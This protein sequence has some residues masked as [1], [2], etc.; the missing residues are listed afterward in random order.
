MRS[1]ILS[2]AVAALVATSAMAGEG[3]Y[4]SG[5]FGQV[6][7]QAKEGSNQSDVFVAA[8]RDYGIYRAE[9]NFQSLNSTATSARVNANLGTAEVFAQYPIDKWTPYVGGGIGYGQFT[10]TGVKKA[11]DG[12]VYVAT[13]GVSYDFTKN[14]GAF[15]QY[16]YLRSSVKVTDA[17]GESNDY[18]GNAMKIGAKYTF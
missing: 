18:V 6:L 5:G 8:G 12:I 1:L 13:A 16:D 9:V 15:A 17:N 7:S 14:W 11:T 10:G 2:T 4:V 3:T